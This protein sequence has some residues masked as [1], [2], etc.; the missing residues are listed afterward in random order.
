[1]NF[2]RT[3]DVIE[4]DGANTKKDT[5]TCRD[6]QKKK[7]KAVGSASG[8]ARFS[9]LGMMPNVIIFLGSQHNRVVL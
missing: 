3:R 9:G 6:V 4:D 7:G 5:T 2:N 1:M 8:E